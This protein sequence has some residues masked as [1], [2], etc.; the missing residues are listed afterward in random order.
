VGRADGPLE[1]STLCGMIT[2]AATGS[3]RLVERRLCR[4][5]GDVLRGAYGLGRHRADARGEPQC[6]LSVGDGIAN[7]AGDDGLLTDIA[8]VSSDSTLSGSG[9]VARVASPR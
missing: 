5:R 8:T 4:R 9:N 7:K 6:R 1:I 3:L 2:V